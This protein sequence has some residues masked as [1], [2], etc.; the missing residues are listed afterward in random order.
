MGLEMEGFTG[1]DVGGE[2]RG[3]AYLILYDLFDLNPRT[4][5]CNSIFISRIYTNDIN[6]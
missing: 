1:S 5:M 3:A 2:G 6:E 4:S